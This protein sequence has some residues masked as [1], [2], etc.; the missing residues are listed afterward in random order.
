MLIHNSPDRSYTHICNKPLRDKNLSLKELGL[1]CKMSSLKDGW[2][3]S[4]AGL[5]AICKDG[6]GSVRTTIHKLEDAGYLTRELQ[7]QKA[8]K[9]ICYDYRLHP[10]SEDNCGYTNINNYLLRD[11]TLS[12]KALGLL[13]RMISLPQ[14]TWNFSVQGLAS[15]CPDCISSVTAAIR[16]LEEH[17][18]LCR[19]LTRNPDGRMS[20][21]VYTLYEYPQQPQVR[22]HRKKTV[23]RTPSV[24]SPSVENQT[25]VFRYSGSATQSKN[26]KSKN[27]KF[28]TKRL[29]PGKNKKIYGIN[30][31]VFLTDEELHI[32]QAHFPVNYKW[33]I[34][35]LSKYQY[36]TG[37]FYYDPLAIMLEWAEKDAREPQNR[38]TYDQNQYQ[39]DMSLSNGVP[40]EHELAAMQRLLRDHKKRLEG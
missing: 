6:K 37:K 14:D 28:T 13:C 19:D 25:T 23:S 7:R 34:D 3:Y 39:K 36:K 26:N 4:I 8:G 15:L 31:D 2:K 29:T 10:G 17:G 16:E 27:K 33:H 24:P 40:G 20:G 35:H 12:L 32:L 1:F 30:N 22:P 38:R 18:Y 11:K 5:A 21:A 9:F